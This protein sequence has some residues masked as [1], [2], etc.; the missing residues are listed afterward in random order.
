MATLADFSNFDK[1]VE[2]V[3]SA[4]PSHPPGQETHYHYLT[5]GWLLGG[6][7]RGAAGKELTEV[8]PPHPGASFPWGAGGVPLK[9]MNCDKED[10]VLQ[11]I[12]MRGG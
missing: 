12:W 6:L 11:G 10:L 8:K 5:F 4:A 7:A 9:E 3:A 1:M 2:H